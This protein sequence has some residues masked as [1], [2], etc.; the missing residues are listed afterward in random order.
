MGTLVIEAAIK[1]GSLITASLALQHN[2]EVFAVPGSIHNPLAQGCHQLIK[3]GA[4]L[5][6]QAQDIIDQLS[7][8]LD[9]KQQ[10]WQEAV[11][12]EAIMNEAVVSKK[13]L[14]VTAPQATA[15]QD[16]SASETSATSLQEQ[17][18]LDALGFDA[19]SI[20]TLALRTSWPVGELLGC[21]SGL[22]IKGL[23]VQQGGTYHPR[24][25]T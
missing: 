6:E 8:M 11:A 24:R 3:Q 15:A 19:A 12:S 1:S 7:A 4:S 18:L 23:I 22:E 10:E 2:R 9:Y 20:D 14:Q 13:V 5:V 21:L 25:R 16:C 17:A